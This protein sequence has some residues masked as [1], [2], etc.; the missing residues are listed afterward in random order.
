MDS[1]DT[2]LRWDSMIPRHWSEWSWPI[3]DLRDLAD[4]W[5]V[6]IV[7]IGLI[8][9]VWAIWRTIQ[10][11][12]RT[13]NYLRL[14]KRLGSNDELAQKRS[15]LSQRKGCRLASDF[16]DLLVEVPRPGEPLEK[17]LKRCGAASEVFNTASMGQGIVGSRLLMAT[18]AILTG[19]G[20]L[21]TFVGLAMG[22]GGLDLGSENI[23]DLDKSIS[24]LIKGSSTAFVTSVWGVTCSILFTLVEKILEWF[25]VLRIRKVQNA[26]DSLAP[27]YT[28]EESMIALHRSASQQEEV[29]K[30]LAV[31]IGEQMQKAMDRI[32][33]G[34]TAAVKD[35]LGG[36]AEDLGKMSADLMSKALTE[37]LANLQKAVSG[38]SDGFKTEF[39]AASERLST[40][41]SGFD[42]ILN[43]V[44]STVKSSREAMDQAVERLTAHEEVVKGLQEGAANLQAAANELGS[45]R[46]T[47]TLSAEKNAEA[48]GAQ[49]N[50][51]SKNELVADKLEKIGEKLPE[52]QEAVAS[53]ARIIASLGQPLLD[54]K[55]ILS[56]TPEIF[57]Q[58]AEEQA[59]RDEKRSNLLLAQTEKL[60]D[61]VA[62]AAEKFSEIETLAASLSTSAENLE[63]ASGAL[64]DLA[65]GINAAS[66]QHF[67]A[68]KASEKAA[69]AGERA[70]EKLEPIPN[71]LTGLSETLESASGSIKQGA[72]AAREVYREL[73]VH[74]KQWF[75]GI[76]T[77][78]SAMRDRVQE[79]LETY[80]ESVEGNTR[81]H[82]ELWTQAVNESLGKFS[83]QVQTLEG[84]ISDLTDEMNN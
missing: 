68:A 72:D 24:P 82:M 2:P 49:D 9:I 47:F 10:V 46:D 80:G 71:S 31:A 51:A 18:P 7:A 28:P 76:E 44:D 50:A 84:A 38:M 60:A 20:V 81:N 34:I 35:A 65:T 11:G 16:N 36:Q 66:E 54:L 21:G 78:L 45:M 64:G 56:K 4:F 41:I 61:T 13:G 17:D 8:L 59:V 55:E 25:A 75:E 22:I 53:G 15:E 14:A 33:E 67:A 57:G 23:E 62:S 52:V 3:D 69:I 37:E 39:G 58:Q 6:G 42:S 63:K 19:L 74:Q 48:A 73:V 40:T 12:I 43:G 70:A 26:F 29:L 5:V 77:G 83:A 79:I 27:R 1:Q 30:G 32:G